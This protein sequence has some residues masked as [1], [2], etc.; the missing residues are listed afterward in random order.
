[1]LQIKRIEG[2]L[3]VSQITSLAKH[4]VDDILLD[5]TGDCRDAADNDLLL[6]FSVRERVTL[7][8]VDGADL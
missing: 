5:L 4:A 3:L 2:G 7:T 8:K 6:W 1:M